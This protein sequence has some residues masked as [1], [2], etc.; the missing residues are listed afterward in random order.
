MGALPQAAATSLAQ[1]G[2]EAYESRV[3]RRTVF[4]Y[5]S[6]SFF[7]FR[8]GARGCT[9]RGPAHHSHDHSTTTRSGSTRTRVPGDMPREYPQMG[10]YLAGSTRRRTLLHPRQTQRGGRLEDWQA[11]GRAAHR[12]HKSRAL[13]QPLGVSTLEGTREGQ[14]GRK[15]PAASAF[16]YIVP[17]GARGL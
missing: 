13:L 12:C 3:T 1:G 14:R 10:Y 6:T 4:L 5:G 15:G 11:G 8:Y 17:A 2:L 7:E 9:R 16:R